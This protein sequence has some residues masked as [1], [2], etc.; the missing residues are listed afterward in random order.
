MGRTKA[1]AKRIKSIA[2]QTYNSKIANAAVKSATMA[3]AVN[4]ILGGP[5]KKKTYRTKYKAV[6][7]LAGLPSNAKSYKT[8]KG[9]K[10]KV[11]RV[12][13]VK[14]SS[15][16]RKQVK[17]V[18]AGGMT[19]GTYKTMRAGVVGAFPTSTPYVAE[20]P[21][22][23]TNTAIVGVANS[24]PSSMGTCWGQPQIWLGS[25][26][27]PYSNYIGYDWNFFTPQ[28]FKDAASILWNS[29]AID[30]NY[31]I[32]TNDIGVIQ[33]GDG[34]NVP[35]AKNAGLKFKIRQSFV[36]IEF[37]SIT[38]RE[39]YIEMFL[40]TPK[41]KT[42]TNNALKDLLQC[43]ENEQ[44]T[45]NNSYLYNGA[46]VGPERVVGEL[47]FQP[48]MSREFNSL[49]TYQKVEFKL[50]AGDTITKSIQ[51][52]SHCDIDY[53]KFVDISGQGEDAARQIAK[54]FGVS[55]FMRLS[56]D[57]Q[58][59]IDE[60]TLISQFAGRFSG[61]DNGIDKVSFPVCVEWKE[62]F[63]LL[64]PDSAG[65]V[66]DIGQ[67]PVTVSHTQTL[68]QRKPRLAFGN[69]VL[70]SSEISMVRYDVNEENPINEIQGDG[71][72]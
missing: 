49:W 39:T 69:F 47:M 40:C 70:N 9:R 36:Q 42:S 56:Y 38:G 35:T 58:Y 11:K 30:N 6:K 37:K 4:Y 68:N 13:Q 64:M 18:I 51:G 15:R 5:S 1:I 50:A 12:K 62:T 66:T 31:Q 24:N 29:K 26:A 33:S 3:G 61:G 22:Y 10:P 45:G 43:V 48:N 65:F 25:P 67:N 27:F 28:R 54:G 52:P 16:L 46:Q 23:T 20:Y 63:D 71:F 19:H 2:N 55:V 59:A 8:T 41:R 21:N 7:V 72:E 53:T 17:Q 60:T 34:Q 44:G 14:V 57:Q 32:T